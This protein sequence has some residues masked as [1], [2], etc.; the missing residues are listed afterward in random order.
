MAS[1]VATSRRRSSV[2]ARPPVSRKRVKAG[3]D[4]LRTGVNGGE[5]QRL[6]DAVVQTV[7]QGILTGQYLP[8]AR[9]TEAELC[10]TFGLSRGPV[11]E[12]LSRL[13]AE[14]VV[15]AG[16]GRGQY[17]RALKR[18][19]ALDHIEVLQ[20]LIELAARLACVR[21]KYLPSREHLQEAHA[22]LEA[23]LAQGDSQLRSIERTRF[24]EVLFEVAGNPELARLH[25]PIT[26]QIL[27]AQV[28]PFLSVADRHSQYADYAPLCEAIL[29]GDARAAVRI[30]GSHLG[31]SRAHALHLPDAAF[32]VAGM[33]SGRR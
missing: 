33:G 29:D 25:A 11:R 10:A 16:P 15:M 17:V 23:A 28:Y 22:R 31:R 2:S 30:V 19:E 24:Y 13:A 32:E 6:P 5:R 27:R 12:A 18:Q 14:G 7:K 4:S 9:L 26:G 21:C 20:A 8:G 3:G 1:P